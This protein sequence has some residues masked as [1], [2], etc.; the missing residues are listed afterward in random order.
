MKKKMTLGALSL[1]LLCLPSQAN[2]DRAMHANSILPPQIS[3]FY[4]SYNFITS[5]S[6]G[7]ERKIL[8]EKYGQHGIPE[9]MK[10]ERL[11]K[12][13][14]RMRNLKD[15]FFVMDS[16]M[17]LWVGPTPKFWKF[18]FRP[19]L[20]DVLG[21]SVSGDTAVVD[22][23]SH[24]VEPETI[25]RFIS[26]YEESNGDARKVPTPEERILQTKCSDPQKVIHRWVLQNGKWKKSV[27][28]IYLLKDKKY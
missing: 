15:Q 20:F 17:V 21:F 18:H 28:D 12:V 23:A 16:E 5:F 9:D 27:D 19:V 2:D 26:A 1:L 7:A 6:T 10:N 11:G 13:F 22:V 8:I 25:L 3:E 24:T 14:I 4:D